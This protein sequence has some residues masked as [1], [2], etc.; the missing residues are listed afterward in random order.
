MCDYNPLFP[1]ESS[2]ISYENVFNC[3]NASD[4]ELTENFNSQKDEITFDKGRIDITEMKINELIP[5]NSADHIRD[6]MEK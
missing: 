3:D 2:D 6:V 5:L 1:Y 4:S